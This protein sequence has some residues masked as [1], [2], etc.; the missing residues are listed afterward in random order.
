MKIPCERPSDPQKICGTCGWCIKSKFNP[1]KII[2]VAKRMDVIINWTCFDWT[3]T[4]TTKIFNE[5][6]KNVSI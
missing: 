3:I 4:K 1:K 6:I 2:C 5:T